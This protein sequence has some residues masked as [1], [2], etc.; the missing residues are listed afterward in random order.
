[1]TQDDLVDLEEM[2][3]LLAA[4]EAEEDARAAGILYG[5]WTAGG[6]PPRSSAGSTADAS[7]GSS[8]RR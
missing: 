7:T 4:Q 8:P 3:R 2:T 1:M 5:P 6:W